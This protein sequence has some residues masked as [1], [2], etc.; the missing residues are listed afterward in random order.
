MAAD[1]RI[2][3]LA[4]LS[5]TGERRSLQPFFREW[6]AVLTQG[7]NIEYRFE[8]GGRLQDL[9]YLDVLA[10]LRQE[11]L[12]TAH[13]VRHG[14]LLDEPDSLP[15]LRELLRRIEAAAEAFRR[16]CQVPA[17]DP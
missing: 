8:D 3:C 16:A 6:I 14:E 4:E 7:R 13:K 5:P 12:L 2:D 9:P 10:A 1:G 15:V 11:T 17:A